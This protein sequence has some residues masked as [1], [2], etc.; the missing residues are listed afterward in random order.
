MLAVL[1]FI[2]FAQERRPQAPAQDF[3]NFS[4]A[5]I[6]RARVPE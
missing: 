6:M 1:N 2:D 5:V 3:F 4:H